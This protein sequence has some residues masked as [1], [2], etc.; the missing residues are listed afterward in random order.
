MEKKQHLPEAKAPPSLEASCQTKPRPESKGSAKTKNGEK[1]TPSW[2]K[3]SAKSRSFLSNQAK[4]RKQRLHQDKQT[5][6]KTYEVADTARNR[7]PQCEQFPL[8][9]LNGLQS[10]C[11]SLQINFPEIS[12]VPC[13]H[14]TASSPITLPI[15]ASWGSLFKSTVVGATTWSHHN[16]DW[17]FLFFL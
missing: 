3:G 1:T 10:T 7:R 6:W 13:C 8:I 5:C 17:A 9:H 4:T 11:Y 12:R 14:A 16:E 15:P 2:S